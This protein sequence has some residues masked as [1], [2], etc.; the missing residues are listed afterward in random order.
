MVE[1]HGIDLSETQAALYE[2]GQQKARFQMELDAKD[3]DIEQ[4]RQKLACVNIDTAS[5]NNSSLEDSENS[6]KPLYSSHLWQLK[7]HQ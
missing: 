1:K 6:G 4:L 3:C 7:H 5:L 2:E